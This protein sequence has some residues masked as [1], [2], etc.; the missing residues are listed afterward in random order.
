[1]TRDNFIGPIALFTFL[2]PSIFTLKKGGTIVL[3]GIEP[4]TRDTSR[5]YN[6]YS[7]LCTFFVKYKILNFEHSNSPQNKQKLTFIGP[8]YLKHI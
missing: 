3:I 8:N 1:M 4:R 6:N 5:P 2:L 7:I